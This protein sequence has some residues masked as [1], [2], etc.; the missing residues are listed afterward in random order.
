MKMFRNE[1]L[2]QKLPGWSIF[3]ATVG[4]QEKQH[5]RLRDPQMF[6]SLAN[7]Q[8][9]WGLPGRRLQSVLVLKHWL[10]FHESQFWHAVYLLPL[11]NTAEH[12]QTCFSTQGSCSPHSVPHIVA[13]TKP[14]TFC[15]PCEP[16]TR[17]FTRAML[18]Q[19]SLTEWLWALGLH[20]G[21]MEMSLIV[22]NKGWPS[23][24]LSPYTEKRSIDTYTYTSIVKLRD[25]RLWNANKQLSF[26]WT[27]TYSSDHFF[28][29]THT[30]IIKY[31][32]IYVNAS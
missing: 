10:A 25:V 26:G 19:G 20:F 27:K 24:S 17:N 3:D 8:R 9:L 21:W 29:D 2:M 30:K 23:L 22:A 28:N 1:D 13:I 31:I 18:I 12:Y 11:L 6:L 32:Y 16:N 14:Y 5:P 4:K 7:D 15:M